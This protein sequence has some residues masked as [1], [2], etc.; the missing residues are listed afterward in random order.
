MTPTNGTEQRP[1]STATAA[2]LVNGASKS[3]QQPQDN[4]S[5]LE[6][7]RPE[8]AIQREPEIVL[9]EAQRAAKALSEVIASKPKKVMFNGEQYL[10]FEDWQTVARFYGL[11]VKVRESRYVEFGDV[12]GFE[13]VADVLNIATE[14]VISAA[15]SMCLDDEERWRSRP[16]YEGY[17]RNRRIVGHEPVPLFQVRSMA[18]TRACAKALRNVLS[19]VVVLAGYRATPAEEMDGVPGFGLEPSDDTRQ[20]LDHAGIPMNTREAAEHIRDRKLAEIRAQQADHPG[21]KP[22]QSEPHLVSAHNGSELAGRPLAKPWKSKGG[23]TE[24]FRIA[25]ERVGEVI[26]NAVLRQ[27]GVDAPTQFKEPGDALAAY[28]LM[29]GLAQVEGLKNDVA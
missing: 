13:A 29:L 24:C 3:P 21:P 5:A 1:L 17:G 16:K 10:E 27:Y 20:A 11:T 7:V 26:W 8:M 12:R 14:Q 18:Q 19:W 6:I 22:P 15:E 2:Q 25:R 9:Q 28:N 4:S 23:M